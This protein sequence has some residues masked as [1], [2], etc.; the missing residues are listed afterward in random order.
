MLVAAVV[1][2]P[3]LVMHITFAILKNLQFANVEGR[4]RMQSKKIQIKSA[5]NV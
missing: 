1:L 4:D 3:R 2:V 5:L